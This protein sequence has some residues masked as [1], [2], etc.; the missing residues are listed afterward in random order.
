MKYQIVAYIDN[1][2]IYET[3]NLEYAK[4]LLARWSNLGN[5]Y[6]RSESQGFNSRRNRVDCMTSTELAIRD[7]VKKIEELGCSIKLTNAINHLHKA[8]ELVADFVDKK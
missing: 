1:T 6:L 5:Y 2:I 7:C 4:E 8:R 3:D